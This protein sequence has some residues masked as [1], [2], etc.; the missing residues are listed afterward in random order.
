M[1]WWLKKQLLKLKLYAAEN[2]QQE[3]ESLVIWY[4]V[5]YALGMGLYLTLPWE[6]PTWL[7]V[8]YMEAV[9]LLLYLYRRQDRYFKI[10]TYVCIL[11]LGLC[12]AKGDALYK[13]NFLEKKLEETSYLTGYIEAVDYNYAGKTRLWL[14]NVDNFENSL[15]GKFRITVNQH[16]EW[17][18]PGKCVELIA[19]LPKDY[20]QNPLG[21]YNF[22]RSLFYQGISASGF[23]VSPLFEKDCAFAEKESTVFRI[24]KKIKEIIEKNADSTEGSIIEALSI[25]DR[26]KLN[27]EQIAAFRTAGLSHILAI[28]GMHM[29]MIALLVFF[30]I[31]LIL[32]PLGK[33]GYDTRK[34]AAVVALFLSSIYFL[35][36]GQS[37][38]CQRA[39]I[40]TLITLLAILFNRRPVSLRL[41]AFA[42]II[43]ATIN[44]SAVVSP[45]FLMSFAA[46][47]GIVS[48]YEKYASELHKWLHTRTI[49]GKIGAYL[50]GVI[51]TDMVASLITLPYSIYYFHQLSVYTTLANMLAAPLMAFWIMPMLLLFLI[52]ILLGLG[53][54]MISPLAQGIEWLNEIATFVSS[55]AG[56]KYGENLGNMPEW[57][58]FFITIGILWLCIWQQKWRI[59]GIVLI[60]IGYIGVWQMPNTDFVFDKGGNTY[61]CRSENGNLMKTPWKKN[62]FLLNMWVKNSVQQETKLTEC[63]DNI[64]HCRNNIKYTKGKIWWKE[65]SV[66]LDYSG[67]I[68]ENRGVFYKYPLPKRIWDK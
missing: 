2:Y 32:L 31:R 30:L 27:Q 17:L 57:C 50:L 46:V 55:L 63:Q 3:A 34:P 7:A 1:I 67:F 45:G 36:S 11:V 24:R 68:D 43:V 15:K 39:Y 40:M 58:L 52:S 62:K 65:K 22:S 12:V 18:K 44:P 49:C 26:T 29:G 38:S 16:P 20:V 28:S 47:L 42:V 21:N 37:V 51:I 14:T 66:N 13:N 8:V 61:A 19:E 64:C 23:A 53:K 4:A 9:L 41:W 48:F 5:C 60:I 10:L 33:N 25:G 56:A 54:Y 59:W 35:I 6:I